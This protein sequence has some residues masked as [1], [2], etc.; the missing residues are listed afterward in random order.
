MARVKTNE[1]FFASFGAEEPVENAIPKSEDVEKELE[2]ESE[3]EVEVESEVED[4]S[5]E[6]SSEVETEEEVEEDESKSEN[7]EV[8][9]EDEDGIVFEDDVVEEETDKSVDFSSLA[10]DFGLEGEI[11]DKQKFIESYKQSLA[12]A[13]EDALQGVPDDL[14][15]AIDFAKEGG[16]FLSYLGV[17]SANYDEVSN[18]ELV[19]VSMEKY[20][21]GEDGKV[22]QEA[23]NEWLDSKSAAE[24]NMMG[25]QLRSS[26]KA[27]QES[28][29]N[30]LRNN[31][32]TQ[33]AESDRK[34]KEYINSLNVIGGVKL[35]QS[36]KDN[37]YNDA[38]TGVATKELFYGEDG[39]L[40]QAKLAENLF[41]VRMFDKAIQLAKT[42][43]SNDGKRQVLKSATNSTVNRKTTAPPAEIKESNPMDVFWKEITKKK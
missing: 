15:E 11:T 8:D 16:D 18:A 6:D 27:E 22:D 41:K 5:V 28:K 2:I 21:K 39:R 20:F 42:S 31:A 23:L 43:A 4:E 25:D 19:E 30:N 35:R 37:L 38:V 33:K 7:S 10:K 9:S 17:K 26:L 13:K 24:I 36:D 29:L 40:S 12:K 3:D 1:E 14:K 32:K 34:L